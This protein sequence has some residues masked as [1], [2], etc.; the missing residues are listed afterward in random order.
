MCLK[1]SDDGGDGTQ[2]TENCTLLCFAAVCYSFC[3]CLQCKSNLFPFFS[4]MRSNLCAAREILKWKMEY[5]YKPTGQGSTD[6][7]SDRARGGLKSKYYE[8]Q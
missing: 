5:L 8:I 4:F 3:M 7:I 2:N 6:Y 1:Y